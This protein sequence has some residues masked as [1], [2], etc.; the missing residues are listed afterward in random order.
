MSATL[1][2]ENTDWNG[3]TSYDVEPKLKGDSDETRSNDCVQL[4]GG[5]LGL[6]RI[7]YTGRVITEHLWNR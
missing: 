7:G 3:K 5:T 6:S 4:S 2:A 1:H